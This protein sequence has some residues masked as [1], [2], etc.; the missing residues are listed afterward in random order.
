MPKGE[1]HDKGVLITLAQRNSAPDA[2]LTIKVPYDGVVPARRNADR[3]G[4]RAP[5]GQ[6]REAAGRKTG[7]RLKRCTLELGGKSAA[8]ILDDADL[9]ATMG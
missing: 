4:R 6:H 5:R 8:I 3:G 7:E 9:G 1:P 2:R